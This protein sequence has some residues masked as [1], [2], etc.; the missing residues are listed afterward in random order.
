MS[1]IGQNIKKLRKVKGLSQQA[2]AELFDLTRGN[3]SSYEEQRAEPKVEVA[4]KIAN[5]FSIPL[6][7]LYD[8]NL[9]VNE[10]LKFDAK[11]ETPEKT[12]SIELKI[13]P[14]LDRTHLSLVS[15]YYQHFEKLPQIHFPIF[16][17]KEFLAVDLYESIDHH[18]DFQFVETDIA[19]FKKLEVDLLHTLD[20]HYGLFY[21]K[22]FFFVGKFKIEGKKIS[23][24]LNGWHEEE[25]N[26]ENIGEFWKLYGIF[27]KL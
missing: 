3:I 9:S 21:N 10:I 18:S 1:Q 20:E 5:Y 27:K 2:F 17:P 12:A 7:H 25:L 23:L 8:K 13:I 11:F 19:F 14:Y 26:M 16:S 24:I 22:D 6:Q 15:E 4:T